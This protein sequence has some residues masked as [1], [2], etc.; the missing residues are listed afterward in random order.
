M[1]KKQ[2]T[3]AAMGFTKTVKHRETEAKI[4][5][6]LEDHSNEMKEQC[7][8]CNKK[9]KNKQGLGVH[10]KCVHGVSDCPTTSSNSSDTGKKQSPLLALMDK[11]KDKEQATFEGDNEEMRSQD[12]EPEAE[13]HSADPSNDAETKSKRRGQEKRF[14]YSIEKKAEI[15]HEFESGATQDHVTN[16]F[17]LHLIHNLA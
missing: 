3:L 1:S 16:P 7:H 9:F 8:L 11:N 17:I 6:P 5:I 2:K 15:L 12:S 4:D 10:V 13:L 14:H